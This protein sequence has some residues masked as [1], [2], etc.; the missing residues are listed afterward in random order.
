MNRAKRLIGGKG[1]E[2]TL[3]ERLRL[4]GEGKY[5]L[6]SLEEASS[7]KGE[8]SKEISLPQ[9]QKST[10]HKKVPK[11]RE[12]NSNAASGQARPPQDGGAIP[13]N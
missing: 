9:A 6:T 5:F 1:T 3:P 12:E 4:E 10:P 7:G 2:T 13:K 11:Y 8:D